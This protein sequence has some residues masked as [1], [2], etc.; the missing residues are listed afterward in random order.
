MIHEAPRQHERGRAA[1]LRELG[2][3]KVLSEREGD[4]HTIALAGELDLVAA[5][6]VE[7]ELERV[8]ATDVLSIVVDLSALTFM[9]PT[10]V[11]LLIDAQARSRTDGDRLLLLRGPA[12]VQRVFELCGVDGL[13]PFAE[14][15]HARR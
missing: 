5:R 14:R 13:L 4:V 1:R 6:R 9:D 2:Q 15:V 12:G 10:G 3:L 7:R 8:E 11:R